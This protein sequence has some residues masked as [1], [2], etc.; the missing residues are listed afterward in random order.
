MFW[1]RSEH[2]QEA[3]VLWQGTVSTTANSPGSPGPEGWALNWER[4]TR[5]MFSLAQEGREVPP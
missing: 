1:S 3:S 2:W 5:G 4:F